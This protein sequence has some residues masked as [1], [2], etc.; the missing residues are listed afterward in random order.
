VAF[1][2]TLLQKAFEDLDRLS[3]DVRSRILKRIRWLG[4]NTTVIVHHRL[5]SLPID[6]AGLCRMRV[7]DYRVLYWL[8]EGSSTITIYR[9]AH[10]STVYGTI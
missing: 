10:R 1:K 9:V 7:G 3:P 8:D 6:L 5:S 2:V 4:E